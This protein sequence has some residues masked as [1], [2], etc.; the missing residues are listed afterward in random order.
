MAGSTL[1]IGGGFTFLTLVFF[2]VSLPVDFL[3]F[4][5]VSPSPAFFLVAFA[6]GVAF[7][8]FDALAFGVAALDQCMHE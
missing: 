7:P 2:A 1:G 5:L 6:F 8:L 4:F 3:T